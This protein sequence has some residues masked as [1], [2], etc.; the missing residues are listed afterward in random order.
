MHWNQSVNPPKPESSLSNQQT[1]RL[2][3]KYVTVTNKPVRER[4]SEGG[5]G[6]GVEI[7]YNCLDTLCKAD[8]KG[9]I[10]GKV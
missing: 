8:W 4:E 5:G 3:E 1:D 9:H 10:K 6:W 7:K 2:D